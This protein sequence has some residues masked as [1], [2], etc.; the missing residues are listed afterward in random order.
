LI[1]RLSIPGEGRAIVR[2][3]DRTRLCIVGALALMLVVIDARSA[4]GDPGSPPIIR[5]IP[6]AQ[7]PVLAHKH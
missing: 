5:F 1:A 2:Q 3:S 4:A 7:N 6:Y